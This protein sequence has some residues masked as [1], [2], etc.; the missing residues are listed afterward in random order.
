[1]F[2]AAAALLFIAGAH[3][4]DAKG[5]VRVQ[6]DDGSV[7]VYDNVTIRIIGDHALTITT[8]D[9]KGTLLIERA[10]CSYAGALLVCLPYSM[11]LEQNG[12]SKLLDFQRGTTYFNFTSEKQPLP[13][14]STTVPPN[15]VLFA[16]NTKIGTYVAVSGTIDERKK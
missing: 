11:S 13:L 7:Q 10:A 3:A 12:T 15:G 4:A 9:G 14:S 6:Q 2:I 16:M 1:M 8:A 5:T